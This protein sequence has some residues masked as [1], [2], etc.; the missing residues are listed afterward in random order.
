MV[1]EKDM[2][3]ETRWYYEKLARK[4][5]K[6]LN[7]NNFDAKYVPDRE[8]ALDRILEIIPPG[9]T[10][11]CGDSVTLH[12]IGF[13]DWL[14]KQKDHEVFNP[15][16]VRRFDFADDDWAGFSDAR[17]RLGR[18]ALTAD[19]FCTGTNAITIDGKL[20]NIDG[21]GNRV[22]PMIFGPG[23]V[24]VVSGFNKIVKDVDEAIKRI[25]EWTAP[26]NNKRHIDKH[27]L[28]F[29]AKL[30]C[31]ITGACNNCHGKERCCRITTIIDGW[32]PAIK[33]PINYPPLILIIG[34]SLGI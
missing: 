25:K 6:A 15:F 17:F 5:V 16:F 8:E 13:F 23:R 12:Q 20:V 31:T 11:G 30:P 10:I 3:N 21:N 27:G 18:K 7:D 2:S 1:D 4:A 32:N 14:E 28:D 24:I 34:E 33:S 9:G 22:A 26:I 29:I 19:V